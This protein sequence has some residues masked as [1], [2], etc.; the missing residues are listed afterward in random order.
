VIYDEEEILP[1]PILKESIN[2]KASD[3]FINHKI[4]LKD[5][6]FKRDQVNNY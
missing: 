5:F 6:K 2:K 3:I 4:S 1:N